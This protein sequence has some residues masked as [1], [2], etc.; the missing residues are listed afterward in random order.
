MIRISFD[1]QI[2]HPADWAKIPT[3]RHWVSHIPKNTSMFEP[4]T[5]L[6]RSICGFYTKGI[7]PF[8]F[9]WNYLRNILMC[10]E[11]AEPRSLPSRPINFTSEQIM[12]TPPPY[13][14]YP[15][16]LVHFPVWNPQVSFLIGGLMGRWE[17]PTGRMREWCG[18]PSVLRAPGLSKWSLQGSQ[19]HV[20][21]SLNR[22]K[23]S[24]IL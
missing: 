14:G 23:A 7:K 3:Y 11:L 4:V 2:W 20:L 19:N 24:H 16:L 6:F 5:K 13:A 12:A 1:P 18:I 9:L 21:S 15:F 17:R 22:S 10:S 8:S